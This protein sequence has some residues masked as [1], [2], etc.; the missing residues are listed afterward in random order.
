MSERTN[1]LFLS[2]SV[3]PREKNSYEYYDHDGWAEVLEK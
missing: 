2:L 3:F 1:A